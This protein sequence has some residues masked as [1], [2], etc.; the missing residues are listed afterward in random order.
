MITEKE[1]FE[2]ASK[3]MTKIYDVL[4]TDLG[5]QYLVCNGDGSVGG[6]FGDFIV[7]KRTGDIHEI[8]FIEYLAIL[9]NFDDDHLPKAHK[10]TEK[11]VAIA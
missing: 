8:D 2:I 9:K 11:G 6:D 1:A 5:T 10:I 3:Y 7:D 4:I